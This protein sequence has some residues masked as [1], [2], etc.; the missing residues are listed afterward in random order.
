MSGRKIAVRALGAVGLAL[1]L[2]AG[3]AAESVDLVADG[4]RP[5]LFLIYTGDVI[6]HIDPCG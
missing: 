5:E 2:A 1:G 3:A 6:G 4:V